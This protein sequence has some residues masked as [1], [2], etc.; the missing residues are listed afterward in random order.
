MSLIK[1]YSSDIK[2]YEYSEKSIL[3]V[4]PTEW[5]RANAESIKSFA[6]FGT[7][8]T[9]DGRPNTPGWIIPKSRQGDALSRLNELVSNSPPESENRPESSGVRILKRVSAI[10]VASS[11]SNLTFD[12]EEEAPPRRRMLPRKLEPDRLFKM[13]AEMK[14]EIT[15]VFN[16]FT[17]EHGSTITHFISGRKVDVDERVKELSERYPTQGYTSGI[18]F[19]AFWMDTKVVIW[20]RSNSCD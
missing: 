5:G 17:T 6:K 9:L 13:V 7:R 15:T 3:L 18:S 2:V 11:S 20:S 8:F 1:E 12:E 10:P 4:T 16:D 19:T 14:E